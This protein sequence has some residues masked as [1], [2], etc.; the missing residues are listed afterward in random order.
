MVVW[1][2]GVVSVWGVLSDEFAG[3]DDSNVLLTM[4]SPGIFDA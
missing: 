2:F 3:F 1:C 4:D